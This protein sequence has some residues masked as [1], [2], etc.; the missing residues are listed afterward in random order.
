MKFKSDVDGLV[1]GIRFYKSPRN[2]GTHVANLWSKSG[3][4]LAS[5]TF[6]NETASGWQQVNFAQP[7]A[8]TA[9]TTYVASYHTNTGYYC[10]DRGYFAT[11]GA[12]GGP[13]HALKDS[14]DGPNGVFV[15]GSA[16]S[17]PANTY[18][19]SNYWVDVV[20]TTP[21]PA[22]ATA[23]TGVQIDATFTAD[24][25]Q[26]LVSSNPNG[27][28]F[29]FASGTYTINHYIL[30]KEANQFI[31]KV[32][33]TCVLTGLDQYRGAFDVQ[34]DTAHQL[35]KGFVIERF[36]AII[37][38]WPLA[39]LQMRDYGVMDDNEVRY[40]ETG[41][42]GRSHQTL[43]NN[44]I[45][46]NRRYGISGGPLTD[47]L[48]E[49]N[50]LSW[51]NTAHYDPNDNAGGSK[52]VGSQSGTTL[53]TWRGNYVHDNYG[54][55]IWSDGNVRNVLYEAN[56]IENNTGAGIDHEI[57]WD[58]IIRNNTL[59]N[60]NTAELGVPKSCW[61]GSQIGVNNSQNVTTSGNTIESIGINPICMVNSTRHE[62]SV[63]PQSLGN[64]S[65]QGNVIKM[66]G[67][68]TVGMTGDTLPSNVK[69]SGNT[70]YVENINGVYW[71]YMNSMTKAQWQAA[72]QDG[73]G[74]FLTW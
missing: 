66:R 72:G 1:S 38:S 18:Q 11:R 42:E 13:L 37:G 6:A 16:S 49:N 12:D 2:T 28:V 3:A 5:T 24:R 52:I 69:F 58:A 7:V 25:I 46:H 44:F 61:H 35:I 51:N 45:H 68:V 60:N 53:L 50:E 32:R 71:Q 63:F 34:F 65:V 29:C 8:I 55:G 47:L 39:G 14:T 70:Y 56:R 64:I 30:L 74:T 19:S 59:R 43:R 23:C 20:I 67:T 4:L 57:S 48:I 31:C 22:T 33:R 21:A 9:G 10:I 73:A 15:Y 41:I 40:C 36:I 62:T 54:Q 27:T 26:Q 17:F